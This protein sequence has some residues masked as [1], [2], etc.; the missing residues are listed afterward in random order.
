M[1][2]TNADPTDLITRDEPLRAELRKYLVDLGSH[3]IIKHPFCAGYCDPAHAALIHY[4]IDERQKNLPEAIAKKDWDEVVWLYERAYRLQGFIE[5]CHLFDDRSYWRLL[6][7]VWI[8]QEILRAN[9][10]AFLNL[11]QSPRKERHHLMEEEELVAFRSLPDELVVFRGV[12]DR[13]AKSLSWTL[14]R[15]LAEWFA[16]RFASVFPDKQPRLAT[17]VVNKADVLAYFI[18][19]KESE[20]I[21]DPK[22]VK[23]FKVADLT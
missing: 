16:T 20:V 21:V 8:D 10:S 14:D 1:Q 7:E 18:R 17:G 12:L 3:S 11:F 6:G 22:S 13:G 9:W 15:K 19:R 4:Q 23:R 5:H 2:P